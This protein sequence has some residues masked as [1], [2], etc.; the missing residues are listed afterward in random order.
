MACPKHEPELAVPMPENFNEADRLAYALSNVGLLVRC[1]NCGMPGTYTH[2]RQRGGARRP[3]WFRYP[4][5]AARAN[6]RIADLT[7]W[8][9]ALSASRAE[10]SN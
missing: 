9:S 7:K 5:G 10:Q 8:A 3:R 4:D 1:K 2:G 6:Q